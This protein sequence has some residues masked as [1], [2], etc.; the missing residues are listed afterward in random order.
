MSAQSQ[1]PFPPGFTISTQRLRIVPLDPNNETH[2]AF[3]A[4][5]WNTDHFIKSCG[6]SHVADSEGAAKFIRSRVLEDYTRHR[7]IFLVLL[8]SGQEDNSPTPIG[9]VSLMQ[10]AL[11]TP[12]YLVPDIGYAILPE[13]NGKGYATEA[14][15]G[16]LEY[17]RSELGIQDAFGFCDFGNSHSRRVLEKVGMD[18][19]GTAALTVFGGAESAIYALPGMNEDLTVYGISERIKK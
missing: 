13:M 15:K 6:P 18:Y 17:A 1:S 4:Y 7:G 3:L 8:P 9:T 12:R 10:G 14:A 11:G 5:L 19:R 16:M 2:C